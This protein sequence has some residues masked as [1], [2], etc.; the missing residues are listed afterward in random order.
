MVRK[1]KS[2][3]LEIIQKALEVNDPQVTMESSSNSIPKWDSLG[4]INIIIALDT[5]FGGKVSEL[6]EMATA[7]SVRKIVEILK[8]NGL[9]ENE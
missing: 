5:V 6:Q 8:D 1:T 4:Q 3:I 2:E 7:G 9:I